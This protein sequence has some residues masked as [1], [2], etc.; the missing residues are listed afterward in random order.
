MMDANDHDVETHFVENPFIRTRER[1]SKKTLDTNAM[2][3]GEELAEDET[4][5]QDIVLMK[6]AGKFFIKDLE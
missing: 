3:G 1:A 4:A 5:G 6:D 2:L